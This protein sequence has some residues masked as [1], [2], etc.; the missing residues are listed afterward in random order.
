MRRHTERV[1]EPTEHTFPIVNDL[2]RLQREMENLFIV[3]LNRLRKLKLFSHLE[4][5]NKH[6]QQH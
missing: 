4:T 6:I 3:M 2:T 1:K 5:K